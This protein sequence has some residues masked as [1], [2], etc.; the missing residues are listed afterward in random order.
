MAYVSKQGPSISPSQLLMLATENSLGL[1]PVVRIN[2][3]QISR[4]LESPTFLQNY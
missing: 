3:Q 4:T 2:K 1:Y